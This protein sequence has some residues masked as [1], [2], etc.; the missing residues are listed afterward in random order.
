MLECLN[1]GCTTKF[2]FTPKSPEGDFQKVLFLA[3]LPRRQAGFRVWGKTKNELF[4]L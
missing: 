1:E 3:P 2:L 4:V